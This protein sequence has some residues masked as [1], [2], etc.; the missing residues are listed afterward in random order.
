MSPRNFF[1][2]VVRLMG[3]WLAALATSEFL[4]GLGSILW[5]LQPV[6]RS[7]ITDGDFAGQILLSGVAPMVRFIVAVFLLFRASWLSSWFYGRADDRGS[8]KIVECNVAEMYQAA[9]RLLGLYAVLQCIRPI[10]QT[11][12]VV[13]TY[14][15]RVALRGADLTSFVQAVLYVLLAVVL[16]LGA[17]RIG[18]WFASLW[19][20]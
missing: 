12:G 7:A 3:V 2:L 11:A 14:D 17:R 19:H 18:N 10:S 16:I 5:L 20:H 4:Y 9:V 8:D 1:V 6:R 13:Y 15:R